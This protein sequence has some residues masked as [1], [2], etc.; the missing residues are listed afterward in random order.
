MKQ[1]RAVLLLCA[2]F[3][4]FSAGGNAR[5]DGI[6]WAASYADAA[7][8]AKKTDRPILLLLTTDWS[9]WGKKMEAETLTDARIVALAAK[10]AAVRA[11]AEKNGA[12]LAKKYGAAAFPALLVLD[13]EGR[14]LARVTGYEA[15]DAFATHLTDALRAYKETPALESALRKNPKDADAAAK[16]AAYAAAQGDAERTVELLKIAEEGRAKNADLSALYNAVA[17]IYQERQDYD[18]A[19]PLF[20]K[21]LALGKDP[22]NLAYAHISLGVCYLEQSKMAEALPEFRATAAVPNAPAELK[23]QALEFL[24]RF[25]AVDSK[26]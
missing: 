11:D 5:A 9:G 10:F 20:Q 16:L 25:H 14:A 7:E 13:A 22:K 17:D 23:K 26:Q 12:G 4:L 3:F 1:N 19:I 2:A 8:D 21:A 15:A 6:A 18:R 24:K